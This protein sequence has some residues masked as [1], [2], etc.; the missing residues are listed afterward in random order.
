MCSHPES[1]QHMYEPKDS[2][3]KELGRI[4]GKG[5]SVTVISKKCDY[6]NWCSVDVMC[7]PWES[8]CPQGASAQ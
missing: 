6:I 1:K 5:R 3:D 8:E 4:C 7:G 2:V